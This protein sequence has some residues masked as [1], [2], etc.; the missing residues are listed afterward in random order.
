MR[1]VSRQAGSSQSADAARA[2]AREGEVSEMDGCRSC[3][4]GSVQASLQSR[5]Q[6][7]ERQGSRRDGMLTQRRHAETLMRAAHAH[8]GCI[9]RT[10]GGFDIN[11]PRSDAVGNGRRK[12]GALPMGEGVCPCVRGTRVRHD[13]SIARRPTHPRADPRINR[14]AIVREVVPEARRVH[15]LR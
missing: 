8:A 4:R 6:L 12:R 13:G 9:T 3:G 1:T 11:G 14:Q 15:Q 10:V 2:C 7:G 5:S